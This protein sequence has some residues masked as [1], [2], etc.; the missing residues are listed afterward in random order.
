[1]MKFCVSV[2]VSSN[3]VLRMVPTREAGHLRVVLLDAVERSNGR[4]L[5]WTLETT[6]L[7]CPEIE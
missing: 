6:G 7:V 2:Q 5:P 4:T 1:M 3:T